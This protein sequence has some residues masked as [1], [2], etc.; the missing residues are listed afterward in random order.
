MKTSIH[1]G[2]ARPQPMEQAVIG[3]STKSD[4]IR[5]LYREG[6]SRSEIRRF[7]GVRYQ[8]VRNVLVRD[9]F[10]E[11]RLHRHPGRESVPPDV[12]S[13][14]RPEQVRVVVG[15]GGRVVIPAA[16]RGVLCIEEGDAVF[17]R[18]E[19]DE[20][21]GGQRRNGSP[22]GSRDGR[23]VRAA[24]CELG[25]RASS[26]TAARSRSGNRGVSPGRARCVGDSRPFFVGS[27]EPTSCPTTAA[28]QSSR[29]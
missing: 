1:A 15:P 25:G 11:P 23:P 13:G 5:A 6:Y 27:G 2:A 19:G 10:T 21:P 14:P 20:L 8:H 7:L 17:M 22:P 12:R 29:R 3:L 26:G 28:T 9:G 24:G 4:K 16:Y 18:V